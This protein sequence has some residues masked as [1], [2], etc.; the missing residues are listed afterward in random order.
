MNNISLKENRSPFTLTNKIGRVLWQ[1]T[2]GCVS[3]FPAK[4]FN[5]L[6][7]AILRMF[8]AEMGTG[9]VVYPSAKIWAPW[10]LSMGSHS[11]IGPHADVLSMARISIG[12]NV[13][14]SQYAVLC[15]GTHDITTPHNDLIAK[16]L[17]IDDQ[18]WICAYAKILPGVRVGTGAVVGMASVLTKDAKP[19]T[20]YGGNPS[21][22]IKTRVIR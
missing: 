5:W 16:P 22:A 21:K 15:A 6:R 11:C 4:G 20:V 18:S 2:F 9:C 13:T 14:I 12:S 10:N 17:F 7:I 3:I 19:W 1:I 8:G